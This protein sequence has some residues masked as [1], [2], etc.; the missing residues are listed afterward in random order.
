M[1]LY[2]DR[3]P[4]MLNFQRIGRDNTIWNSQ[5]S[6]YYYITFYIGICVRFNRYWYVQLYVCSRGT[7]TS[8]S[9]SLLLFLFLLFV[10]FF[11]FLFFQSSLLIPLTKSRVLS[12]LSVL[13]ISLIF[14]FFFF[15]SFILPFLWCE[16]DLDCVSSHDGKRERE[17]ER[18]ETKRQKRHSNQ[19]PRVTMSLLSTS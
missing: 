12:L 17:R 15:S 6:L 18:K 3:V 1:Q 7:Q 13:S 5:R 19:I 2:R 8:H 14:L 16:R 10:F 4:T 9:T 11:L